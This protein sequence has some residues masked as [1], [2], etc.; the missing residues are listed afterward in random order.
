MSAELLPCPF[1]GGEARLSQPIPEQCGMC[2]E[3]GTIGPMAR[4]ADAAIAAWN[5]RTPPEGQP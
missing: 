1:C 4:D 5:R 2:R 3:C